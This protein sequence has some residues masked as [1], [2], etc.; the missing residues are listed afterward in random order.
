MLGQSSGYNFTGDDNVIIG[1]SSGYNLMGQNNV[2]LGKSSG[3][4]TGQLV[5]AIDSHNENLLREHLTNL[6]TQFTKSNVF[7]GVNSGY[8]TSGQNNIFLGENTGLYETFSNG[9]IILGKD[10]F[11]GFDPEANIEIFAKVANYATDNS[12]QNNHSINIYH[13]LDFENQNIVSIHNFDIDENF[14]ISEHSFTVN[15][16]EQ[17]IVIDI[18]STNTDLLNKLYVIALD[19]NTKNRYPYNLNTLSGSEQITI[20]FETDGTVIISS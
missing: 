3:Y 7:L 16:N 5:N 15:S 9:S 1:E 12:V 13:V 19:N 17:E 18:D 14:V 20:Q 8:A 6:A 4:N 10:A 11:K 2:L